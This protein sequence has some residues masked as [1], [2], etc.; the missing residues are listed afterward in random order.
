MPPE[1]VLNLPLSGSEVRE[2]VLDRIS[3]Y[4]A[5]D[6]FLSPNCA[7][8]YF[9]AEITVHITAH[10]VGRDAVVGTLPIVVTAGTPPE[11][12]DEFLEQADA[13]LEIHPAAPNEVRVESGQPVP[14]STTTKG[15]PDIKPVQYARKPKGKS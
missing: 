1:K 3:Q 12:E 4:L 10:D 14:V 5:Q 9:K 13:V 8:E 6:C 11:N 7:Y 15:K 2:A